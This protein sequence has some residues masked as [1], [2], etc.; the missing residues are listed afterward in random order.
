[1]INDESLVEKSAKLTE[2]FNKDKKV[3]D[4][5][6]SALE[7]KL[8]ESLTREINL[9]KQINKKEAQELLDKKTK[10]LPLF[11]ARTIKKRFAGA[12]VEEIEKNFKKLLE[13]VRKEMQEESEAETKSLEEEISEIIAKEDD[14]SEK[15]DAKG[16]EPV[17]E[18]EEKD[19]VTED[20]ESD[21]AETMDECEDGAPSAEDEVSLDE[22]E[23]IPSSFMQA[24]ISRSKG[25]TPIG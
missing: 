12:S 5:K 11:E 10:D 22:S 1:M 17:E 9:K 13:S 4:A 2:A 7:K 19:E 23:Q 24:W 25:I 16:K 18:N 6:I 3:L 15:E 14:S 21:D 8:N 20:E